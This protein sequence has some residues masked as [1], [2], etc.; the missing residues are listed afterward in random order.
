MLRLLRHHKIPDAGT[1]MKYHN[2]LLSGF[3]GNRPAMETDVGAQHVEDTSSLTG[4]SG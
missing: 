4:I 3:A 1:C 2:A